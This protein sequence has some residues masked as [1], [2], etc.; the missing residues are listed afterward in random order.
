MA[1]LSHNSH[2]DSTIAQTVGAQ[3]RAPLNA[4]I[5]TNMKREDACIEI[6]PVENAHTHLLLP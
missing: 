2:N 3:A 6:Q 1:H 5:S 4:K